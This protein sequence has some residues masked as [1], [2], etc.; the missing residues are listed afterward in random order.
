MDTESEYEESQGGDPSDSE[1][2]LGYN[3][4]DDINALKKL[5]QTDSEFARLYEQVEAGDLTDKC[6]EFVL[7]DGISYHIASPI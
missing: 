1:E 5:Q 7:E 3:L 2:R 6:A 4:P